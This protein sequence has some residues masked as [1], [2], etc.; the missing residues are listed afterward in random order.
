[1]QYA[2]KEG[3]VLLVSSVGHQGASA[4]SEVQ[5]WYSRLRQTKGN[6]H[7]SRL[8]AT[9]LVPGRFREWVG[10]VHFYLRAETLLVKFFFKV[11]IMFYS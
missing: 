11:I 6:L 5:L 2:D 9:I 4:S 7:P 8:T 10:H 1:M 3:H